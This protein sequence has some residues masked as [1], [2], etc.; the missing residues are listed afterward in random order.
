MHKTNPG[1]PFHIWI[2]NELRVPSQN[3]QNFISDFFSS[4]KGLSTTKDI[5]PG[6]CLSTTKAG[7]ALRHNLF[8]D[9]EPKCRGYPKTNGRGLDPRRYG[10]A[11]TNHVESWNNVILKVRDLPIHVFNE[12][13]RRIYSEMSYMYREEAEKSQARL[14]PWATN[15]Y[16]SRK[17]VADSLTCRVS[18]KGHNRHS[19]KLLPIPSDDNTRPTMAP[20]FA[21]STEPPV[22][23]DEDVAI[24]LH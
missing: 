8:P 10:V 9:P 16:E 24:S 21:M 19:W 22:I 3:S 2:V 1:T 17:F 12:K 11:Y 20:S 23:S 15:H 6:K 5:G 18:K 14:A 7:E 4:G 13:L